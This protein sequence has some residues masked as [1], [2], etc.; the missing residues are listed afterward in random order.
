[1]EKILEMRQKR[2]V[3]IEEARAILDKAEEEERNLTEEEQEKYDGLIARAQEAKG[4]EDRYVELHGLGDELRHLEVH[5]PEPESASPVGGP[6]RS[7]GEQLM[8]VVH[9]SQPGASIDSRLLEVRAASGLS[10]GIPADGGFLVQSDFATELLK[11]TYLTGILANRCRKIPLSANSNGIKINAVDETSR[12][13]GSRWGGV[14]AYWAA[15]AGTVT[16]KQPKFRQINLELNKLMGLCYGTDELIQDAA[17]LE[18]VIM[19]AFSEEFGFKLDD[20]IVNGDGA[21]KPLGIMS[22]PCKV[23]VSKETGQSAA[24]VVTE[25]ILKMWKRLWARSRA[26]SV[27]LINQDIEDQLELLSVAIGTGGELARLYDPP[28][29][30][31]NNTAFGKIKGRPVMPIEQC[32]TLGTSGD[33]ILADLSQYVLVDKSAMQS[34][35]SIHVKFINDETTFRF[36][37]RVDGQPIWNSPLT[38]YKGSN[39]LSPFVVLATRS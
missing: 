11:R 6:F 1:M 29:S 27:W 10:E 31:T 24:T 2:S 22:S 9:S 14:L 35:S 18:S 38:P 4:R 26:N 20:A 30:P 34:A 5:K 33:I 7:L 8:A 3:L 25:N 16:A 15:E 13:D 19:Q 37:Y 32:Q 17:A 39:T 36:I 12:A 23:S 21:G 28:G